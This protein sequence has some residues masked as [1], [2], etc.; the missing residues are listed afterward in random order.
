MEG[1]AYASSS[2]Y[3]HGIPRCK[4]LFLHQ[5]IQKLFDVFIRKE[6]IQVPPLYLPLEVK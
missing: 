4:I 1:E 2:F 3:I 5:R 6:V